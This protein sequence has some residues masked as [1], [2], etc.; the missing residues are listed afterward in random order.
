M[1]DDIVRVPALDLQCPLDRLQLFV[2]LS[3]GPGLFPRTTKLVTRGKYWHSKTRYGNG[4]DSDL[5]VEAQALRRDT[6]WR[7]PLRKLRGGVF[8]SRAGEHSRDGTDWYVVSCSA[9]QARL[10]LEIAR[11]VGDPPY[12]WV[13]LG[14]FG[15]IVRM[16]VGHDREPI[17]SRARVICSELTLFDLQSAGIP[18]LSRVRPFRCAP[19]MFVHSELLRWW[20]GNAQPV[21][22]WRSDTLLHTA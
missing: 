12:D 9:Q 3:H 6:S 1:S 8:W 14:R 16:I 19:Q 17:W 7:H 2:G 18:V 4:T 22:P 20:E 15:L 21:D 10:A 13:A 11:G 5:V